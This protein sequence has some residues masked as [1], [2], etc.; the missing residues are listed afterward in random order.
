MTY[1]AIGEN[2]LRL[3]DFLGIF[4]LFQYVIN[5]GIV[6]AE[7]SKVIF[8]RRFQQFL[9][10]CSV[11]IVVTLVF[12]ILNGRIMYFVQSV[13]Y[14]YHMWLFFMGSVFLYFYL[15]TEKRYQKFTTYFIV[16]VILGGLVI[17]L[18]NVG[19][20]P[21][22]WN[23]VYRLGYQGFLSGTFGPNKIVMGMSMLIAL[24]FLIGLN[25]EKNIKT[26][27]VLIFT[28]IGI[29]AIC[30]LL[31]GS[32]TTYV[33]GLVFL[34]YFFLTKTGRFFAFGIF[35]G[36]LFGIMIIFTPTI[37]ER[38][39]DTW[40]NRVAYAVEGPEDIKNIQDAQV[41]YEELSEGRVQLHLKYLEYLFDNPLVIPFGRGFNNRMGVGNS[42]HNQ[43]LS[44]ISEVGIVGLIFFVRWLLSYMVIVKRRM[45]GLQLALNGLVLSMMVTLY[46]GEHLYIYRPLFGLLGF[47]MLVCVLLIVPLR[48]SKK[49]K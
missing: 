1:S 38:V 23:E 7:I 40:Y 46:F 44:L 21:F 39:S 34:L 47:F 43:Y 5:Y 28:A 29:A 27:D 37:S 2:E 41:V 24:I 19:L 31:S 13:L 14:L 8:L 20:V 12:S 45:P 33:G 42:A 32:R 3:Y 26:N 17:I 15:V 18:Q 49:Y 6:S 36:I 11:S 25:S 48:K 35:G 10:Y 30:I 16:L 9:W 4:I 22:L